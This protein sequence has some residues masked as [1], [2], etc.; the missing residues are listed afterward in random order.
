MTTEVWEQIAP[1]VLDW[2]VDDAD[3]NPTP[4]PSE[5]GGKQFD[6][7]SNAQFWQIFTHVK[8]HSGG[9]VEAKPWTP[10]KPT[11]GIDGNT[12]S[13]AAIMSVT[14]NGQSDQS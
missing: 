3:G 6:S 12:N 1:F 8:F 10:S 2:N 4:P 7:I 5:A 14:G 13:D 11:D 9:V